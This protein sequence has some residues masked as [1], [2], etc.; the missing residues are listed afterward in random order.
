MKDFILRG[1]NIEI[2]ELLRRVFTYKLK[3]LP[4]SNIRGEF[5]ELEKY[6]SVLKSLL[7]KWSTRPLRITSGLRVIDADLE[8]YNALWAL[9]P[10][11]VPVVESPNSI[12]VEVSLSELD[13]YYNVVGS[14]VRVYSN[15]VDLVERDIP[16]PIVKLKYLSDLGVNVWAKLE[17]YHPFSLS[18]KDRVAWYMLINAIERG[19]VKTRKLYE[20]TSTNT[21]LGLVGLANYY[22]LKVRVYLPS[23][24]QKCID[25]LFTALGAEVVR[26]DSP[27]TVAMVNSVLVDAARDGAVVLNQFENDLNFIVH[28]KYTAKEIDYQLRSI[29]ITPKAI[30][31]GLGTSGHTSAVSLYFKNRY[32]DV[33]ICGVQPAEGSTIPGIRRIETGMKWIRHVELDEV[34]DVKLEDAFNTVVEV[35]RSDGLLIG[36][37]GGAVLYALR[38]LAENNVI[39]GNVVAIIPD[40]GTKYIEI[41]ES[42]V[43][44]L[45]PEKPILE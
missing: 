40:H 14:S 42:L 34:V 11:L 30:I 23:T 24:V 37:S 26:K 2:T 45:C 1:F 18:I 17:W 15:V 33:K 38:K 20:A 27:I 8:L 21:G 4:L 13:F 9:G 32:S 39:R 41:L 16:T 31:G 28:L 44:K 25:Y 5:I 7:S 29:G 19:Y 3:Y 43:T 36:L 22:N 12:D 10:R 6:I 35:A